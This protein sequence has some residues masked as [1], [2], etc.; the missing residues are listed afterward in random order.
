MDIEKFVNN[1]SDCDKAKL[2]HGQG[3]WHTHTVNGLETVM[4]TDGPHGLRKQADKNNGINDSVKATCFPTASAVASSWN[5]SNAARIGEAIAKEAVKEN[6]SVVLGPGVNI[7][8]SP[9]CGRN[10]EYFSEDP[11]LAGELA[12]AYVSSM[13]SLGVGCSL[14]HFAV[15]SQET[16][17]MTIN[18]VVDERALREIYLAA[19]ERVVKQSQPYT[20]MA[21]YNK[22]NGKY[23]TENKYLLTDI[24][25]NEWG[26]KGLV[27][28][29]WGA[30]Y[31][32]ARAY[33]AGLDLEM[34]E[35]LSGYHEKRTLKA[36]ESGELSVQAI[37][38]AAANVVTLVDKCN[39]NKQTD[40]ES[41]SNHHSV[42]KD[43]ETDCA[44]L[45]KNE[46]NLL[47]ISK[48]KKILVVGEL[49]E[50]PRYQGAGSS[51]V[52][53]ECKS[54][55]NVLRDNNVDFTYAKGY[56]IKGDKSIAKLEKEA[57][58]LAAKC[59]CILFF[60]GLTED[61]EGEGYDREKLS[62]PNCQQT[63][64]GKLRKIN[65]NIAFI[66]FGGSP[67][68]MPWLNKAKAMLNMYLGGEAV[69]EAAYELIFGNVSP[70]GRLA[71][72]YPRRMS[73]IPCYNYFANDRIN[74]EHRES[75]FV[76]YRYYNSY[77]IRTLFPFGYG[78]SY[79]EFEYS[80]F[81]VEQKNGKVQVS[82]QI[83]NVGQYDASEVVQIYV[84]NCD[85][86]IL[87]AK[88]E[89]RAFDKVFVK[90]G[91]SVTVGLTLD[92]RAFSVYY[93]GGYVKV[94]GTYG[95]SVCKNVEEIILKED[96]S[97]DG[98]E[99]V[100]NDRKLYPCYYEKV[101]GS[102]TIE[103][104]QFYRLCNRHKK[105]H[106]K[107]QRGEYTLLNTLED[108]S[109]KVALVRTIAKFA[110]NYT[111]KLSPTKSA[112]DPVAQMLYQGAITTPIISLMSVGGIKAK[113]AMFIYYHA[114]KKRGKALK[115][116][117]GKYN[118]E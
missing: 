36:L 110:K 53:A 79:S 112:D 96:I 108:M 100:G 118:I 48:D 28:S 115:S 59:D 41:I 81:K 72:T 16:R 22:I 54:F 21:A 97:V 99:I 63:L 15:N 55:L 95:V 30:C 2:V 11:M 39:V 92:E 33:E 103:Q 74:D 24:L 64:L 7:K 117:F 114:N 75:I 88:R 94:K 107:L 43:I 38:R 78:L 29:D 51:H 61:F 17:R 77:G 102:F 82:V 86:G 10:F 83:T 31:D 101:V 116:L 80:N 90:A 70:S 111:R 42:A 32:M 26:F 5:K 91:Q 44:V 62:V 47:P 98:E 84:D 73:D 46:G 65:S 87:R 76:G 23:A 58:T 3:A 6:V 89:L 56:S 52:N 57:E 1:L 105:E 25:R 19:F 35:D 37:N 60:G 40:F 66:A 18:A 13:Q 9:L 67:F 113:Y 34:P 49:A 68:T 93:N 8:R 106:P 85:C 20:V 71:E 69:T 50:K 104:G 12:S 14:K 45:L 109:E 27:M 4:M